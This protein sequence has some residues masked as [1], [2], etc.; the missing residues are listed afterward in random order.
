MD[1][2]HPMEKLEVVQAMREATAQRRRVLVVGGRT[3]IDKGEPCEVDAELWTTLLNDRVAYDP[4]D[5]TVACTAMAPSLAMRSRLGV[6][7]IGSPLQPR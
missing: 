4:A 5:W 2:I 6:R 7:A 3:H 1:L